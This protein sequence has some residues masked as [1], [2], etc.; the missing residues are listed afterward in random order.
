VIAKV[1]SVRAAEYEA[2]ANALYI[3]YIDDS[4]NE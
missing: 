3:P 2:E 4:L 1:H